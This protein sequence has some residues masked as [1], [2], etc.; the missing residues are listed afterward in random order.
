MSAFMVLDKTINRVITFLKDDQES[1]WFRS[2]H[3]SLNSRHTD[4]EWA[5]LGQ[6]LFQMNIDG[7]DSRY[8]IGE[9]AGFRPLDYKFS[10]EFA[11]KIQVLKS[12]DCL[13]Y[14]CSEG[15]VPKTPLF[16]ALNDYSNFLAHSIVGRLPDYD[17][18]EW[19]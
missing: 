14:Q 3:Y 7:V 4:E 13:L 17:K 16:K 11:T 1:K 5:E 10:Y 18:A 12:L 19:D 8:G 9:A 6:A 2:E 15:E